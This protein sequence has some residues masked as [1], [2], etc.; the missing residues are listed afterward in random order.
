MTTSRTEYEMRAVAAA[1][2]ALWSPSHEPR[3]ALRA[4][5]A[6]TD[7]GA[8]RA[9]GEVAAR[10]A[11][12]RIRPV[13][14]YLPQATGTEI[15]LRQLMAERPLTGE[16]RFGCYRITD[17]S[18]YSDVARQVECNV[19]QHFF[20]NTPALL[21]DEYA[22]YEAASTFLLVV[23]RELARPAGALRIIAHSESG[24]KTLNDIARAPLAIPTRVVTEHHGIDDLERCWDVGALAVLK[25]YRGR[26][27]DHVVSTMLYGLFFAEVR[28]AN[29][30]HVFAIID[31]HAYGQLTKMLGLPFTTIADSQ[32][33]EY[34]GSECNYAAYLPVAQIVPAVEEYMG[35]LELLNA[36]RFLRAQIAR[37][38][39]GEGLPAVVD[40]TDD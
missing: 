21:A 3:A 36:P 9:Y 24:L 29:I 12:P 37:V 7:Y 1:P 10:E 17:R 13:E 34:L 28:R 18:E 32:P 38:I 35:R 26:A 6:R 31:C 30:E 20:G 27:T 19:F 8:Q 22:A 33:F 16:G 39:Y 14:T 5:P 15:A 25:D 11:R 23:D 4:Q 2:A 40:V